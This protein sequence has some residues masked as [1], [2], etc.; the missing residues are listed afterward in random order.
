MHMNK[1]HGYRQPVGQYLASSVCLACWKD[2]HTRPRCISH[3]AYSSQWC[4]EFVVASVPPLHPQQVADL[5]LSDEVAAKA[6]RRMGRLWL[7]ADLPPVQLPKPHGWIE[8]IIQP[9]GH[10]RDIVR[11]ER[12][13][14]L[15]LSS[16]CR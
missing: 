4:K 2:F 7:Q 15:N 6:D 8:P 11:H 16:A 3:V 12:V 5:N 13:A 1:A 9:G 10:S 14:P